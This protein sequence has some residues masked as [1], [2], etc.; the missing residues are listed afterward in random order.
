MHDLARAQM[1]Y[2]LDVGAGE[3]REHASVEGPNLML[4]PEAA[5]NIGLALHELTANALTFGALSVA[6]GGVAL[7]W[8]IEADRF[9]LVWRE[10]GGPAV[11]PPPRVGFGH[12]VLRRLVAQALDGAATLDFPPEGFVW[13]LSA[14]ATSI[15]ANWRKGEG[16][17]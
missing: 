12:K 1:A 14:P 15:V 9:M 5:Q 11:S 6:G 2:C 13:T 16:G 3:V 10:T 7:N 17:A 8:R 4:K